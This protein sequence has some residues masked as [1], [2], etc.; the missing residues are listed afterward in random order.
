[1]RLRLLTA[2]VCL[3]VLVTGAPTDTQEAFPILENLETIGVPPHSRELVASI[4]PFNHFRDAVLQ[5]WEPGRRALLMTTRFGSLPQLHQVSAPLGTRRQLTFLSNRVAAARVNPADAREV[6]I[7]TDRDGDEFF[8][9]ELLT[10][11]TPRPRLITAGGRSRHQDAVW[12]PHGGLLAFSSTARNGRDAD[13]LVMDPRRPGSQ[14]IVVQGGEDQTWRPASWS[15]D[16]TQLL[17]VL[18]RSAVANE[19]HVVDVDTGRRDKLG[20]EN[21]SAGYFLPRFEPTGRAVFLVST[22]DGDRRTLMRLDL[23]TRRR[24]RVHPDLQWDVED[25]AVSDRHVAY[26][27]NEDGVSVLHVRTHPDHAEVVLPPLPKGVITHLRWRRDA[28]EVAFTLAHARSPGDVYSVTVGT[29]RLDRWTLSETGGLDAS[30]Y[31]EPDLVRWTSF[32]G[33]TISGFYY[34]PP[35]RFA[36]PRPVIVLIHGGP[37]SQSL[38]TFRG[39]FNYFLNE[40]GIALV[41]PNVRGSAGYGSAFLNADNGMKREDAVRDIGAVL[42]WI[43]TRPELDAGR[44]MVTG[45]S[46]GG[47]MTLGTMM[48]FGDRVRCAIV[49]VGI[50]DFRTFLERTE[51]YRRDLRRAEYGDERDPAMRAFFERIAPL[52]HASRFTKPMFIVAGRLDPRVPWQEGRQ[53]FDALQANDVPSWF[54]VAEDEGHGFAKREN[55]EYLFAASVEFVRRFLLN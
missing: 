9:L 2:A 13:V 31:S 25:L 33:Q 32:D 27:A 36:G 42:D 51:A 10:P 45:G 48:L 14:R 6:V 19:L 47:Y 44:V 21:P 1:V 38:P 43:A 5:D 26:V 41:L 17:V 49:I 34:R 40:L 53:M 24:T 4:E 28:P 7:Q 8:Q 12:S 23:A 3:S 11:S 22:A 18:V 15:A 30:T 39:N 46:Y 37:E 52:T 55:Q 50:S 54:L 16:G 35:A 29:S 20:P